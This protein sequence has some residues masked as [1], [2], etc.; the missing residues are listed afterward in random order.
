MLSIDHF[1]KLTGVSKSALRFYEEKGLL[2]PKR[3]EGN[4]Y[5]QY[6]E[7]EVEIARFINSL[8]LAN[9]PLKEI[10]TYLSLSESERSKRKQ[11]WIHM[12]EQK[13]E[14]LDIQIKYLKSTLEEVE[15]FLLEVE[16]ERVLWVYA[17]E[18]Q[19]KFSQ[20]F[21]EGREVLEKQQISVDHYYLQYI[22]GRETVRAWVGFGIERGKK[23]RDFTFFDKEESIRKSLSVA[24]M[25]R[26]DFTTI[27]KAYHEIMKYMST[28]QYI[29]T[30]P[31][32]ERYT[33]KDLGS[34][35]ILIPVMK[36]R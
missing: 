5:R 22:S 28:N 32:M 2:I 36:W 14:L 12:L 16:E 11:N 30:G 4:G 9:V 17:E 3:N 19:G 26:G 1:S 33:G 31:L 34:A 23:I 13:R 6:Q 21:L 35:T 8:R 25:Y 18:E 15:I 24:M 27:E 29:P 7:E 10:K 20:Y